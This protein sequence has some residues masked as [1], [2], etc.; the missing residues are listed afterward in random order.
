MIV[1]LRIFIITTVILRGP[2]SRDIL[3]AIMTLGGREQSTPSVAQ[4]LEAER[5][6]G[7]SLAESWPPYRAVVGRV[8]RAGGSAVSWWRF[9]VG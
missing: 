6:G 8:F 1:V 9:V 7:W 4:L 3:Y 2:F 5:E